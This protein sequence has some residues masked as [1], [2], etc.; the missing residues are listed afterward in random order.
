M[1]SRP[2]LGVQQ[3]QP[4]RSLSG[5]GL[6]QRP[7]HQRTLSQQYLPTSPIRKETFLDFADNRSDVPQTQYGT[8][9][10]GGSRLKLELSHDP[11]EPPSL[12]ADSPGATDPSSRVMTPSRMMPMMMDTSDLGALSP[13]AS[14]RAQSLDNDTTPLPMPKRRPRFA[15]PATGAAVRRQTPHSSAPV[16]AGRK[17]TRPKPYT[18][19]VPP[20]APHFLTRNTG[21]VSGAHGKAGLSAYPMAKTTTSSTSAPITA[22]AD[23]Y[24]WSGD[25][26]ED[27]FSENIIRH[28]F[29]DKAPMQ[30][31]QQTETS[32]AKG[33]LFPALKHK[34]GLHALSSVFTTVLAQRRHNGQITSA[35][36]FKPPP[37]VTL[38]DTKREVWLKD[39]ANPTI[40]LRRLSR[41]IPHGIRGK[42]LLEQCLNKNVPT[43]RAVW[44][45]KCVGANEIRAFKRKGV[46]GALVM[47]GEAKW[48]RDWTVFV[49]TFVDGVVSSFGDNE[50]RSKVNYA[51]RL[52]THLYAEHLMDRDHYMEWLVTGLESSPQSKLPMWLL[53]IQIY[54]KDLLRLRKYGRRLVTAILSHLSLIQTNPDKD[55]LT[56]LS[57][58]LTALLSSILIASPEN[59]VSPAPWMKA[60]ETLMSSLPADDDGLQAAIKRIDSRNEQLLASNAR[61]QPAVRHVL[62]K[63]LDGALQSPMSAD[64]PTQCWTLS[65]DKVALARTLLEWSTS[66]Y[67]PE[68][69]KTYV[70]A[71][72]LEAWSRLG[73]DVTRAILDFIDVDPLTETERKGALYHLISELVRLNLFSISRYIQWLIARGGLY[74][75]TDVMPEGSC[76]TRLLV[77]LPLDALNDSLRNIRANMLERASYSVED[78]AADMEMAIECVKGTLGIPLDPDDPMLHR[79]PLSTKQLSRRIRQSSRALKSRISSWVQKELIELP[80]QDQKDGKEGPEISNTT[81]NTVRSIL[82]AAEDFRTLGDYLRSVS[83]VSNVLILA[84]C[85]DTLNLYLPVM[86]ASG[87]AT[88]LFDTLMGRLKAIVEGQ[89]IAARP[90]LSSLADL[91]P[92]FPGQEALGSQLKQDLARSD[93]STAV[94]ACSPVSDNMAGRLQDNEGELH[95]E[96]EKLLMNGTSL[97]RNTMTRLFQTVTS[98]L[99]GCWDKPNERLRAYSVLLTRLRLFDPQT[100]D[101][102]M[103]RW[104]YQI[105]NSP[106]RPPALELFPLLVSVGCLSIPIILATACSDTLAAGGAANRLNPGALPSASAAH[107]STRP[108]RY[109]Q[110]IIQLLTRAPT[111]NEILTPEECYRFTIL[112]AEAPKTH[113]NEL[114]TLVRVALAEYS[115]C[116]NRGDIADLPLDDPATRTLLM[117]LLR[118][119]VMIDSTAVSRALGV[120]SLDASVGQ[121]IDSITTGLL[122][123]TAELGAKIS[124]DQV[125]GLAN[126]FTLPF[127][128]LKLSLGLATGDAN[129]ADSQDRLQSHVELF[130]KAMDHAIESRNIAWT[131]MLPCLSPE[132]TQHL[133]NRA[134]ARLFE[135]LPSVRAP[136]SS[137]QTRQM[138]ENLLAVVDT[139]IRGGSMG[140]PP[141]LIP[142]M[143]EKLS[144][145]WEIL[146]HG[147]AGLKREVIARWLPLLLDFL[148]LH[149]S[150]FDSSK[151]SNEVRAKA[152]LTLA[153]ILLELDALLSLPDFAAA[154]AALPQRVFDLAL[155][156]VDSVADDV[157]AQCVRA[158]R[159]ATGDARVRYIFSFAASPSE[160][161]MLAHKD[162]DRDAGKASGERPRG[163]GLLGVNALAWQQAQQVPDRL[164]V[165]TI[166][167]WEVLNE[168]TPNVGENDTSLSL[169]LF[170]AVKLQ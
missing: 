30:H 43:D 26:P 49:E 105:R 166:R 151:P 164:S 110:E 165:F 44:L 149:T 76:G 130:A 25:H 65:Q 32:S 108:S 118:S 80:E 158:L 132:I 111:P 91:A 3:R 137:E 19:E 70:A 71:R 139:I 40:S 145:M 99:Q 152:A 6:S 148:T 2:P 116:Q 86:A 62:V 60:R 7:P 18:I 46:N 38:T 4:Q 163:T 159:D 63:L 147:E 69:A 37:R 155:L 12:L 96:I 114:V 29:F 15:L 102:I 109:A 122:V 10:R 119:L 127:C 83:K 16:P 61:T 112:Q 92:K 146:A 9:R 14:A 103:M 17:D 170:D 75:S 124:F 5:S 123:P 133:K 154:A 162:K 142:A 144:D 120:K 52:A 88:E 11:L 169:T 167:R 54:W 131:G 23:F 31:S 93:R 20:V 59:F 107:Q 143:V 41:T 135:I 35:S 84:S 68:I 157:R 73:L 72:L 153:G 94:D 141:Q 47:G 39:L 22:Y 78:E 90:L 77:E 115:T 160:H 64:L 168:P 125:L 13:H 100:F 58:R 82:E 57:S 161:L 24:P 27:Q 150:N 74:D 85:V 156:L 81:F 51:I 98:R 138:A 36:T 126:D 97:D 67:R 134:Q 106:Q 56:P 89:G 136:S 34:S 53:I 128:Q 87:I 113:L 33:A 140:R 117:G 121:V 8:P 28:G 55:I 48:I 79:K 50:W 45:A 101:S 1:T 42:V 129:N 95:E 21:K 66:V 104:V